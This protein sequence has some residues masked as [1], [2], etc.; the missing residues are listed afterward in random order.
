MKWWPFRGTMLTCRRVVN[1][2]SDYIDGELAPNLQ[3]QLEAHLQDC[4]PCTAFIKT[5]K[6]T[7][8][9]ARAVHYGDMPPELRQRLRGFLRE[10]LRRPPPA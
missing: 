1:L 3:H 9:M 2:L 10:R 6:Q 8:A 5:F 7:Q 4:K